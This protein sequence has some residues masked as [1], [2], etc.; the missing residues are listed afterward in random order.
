[1]A[2]KFNHS[3]AM[4]FIL[5]KQSYLSCAERLYDIYNR[6]IT[7]YLCERITEDFESENSRKEV[8]S[9]ISTINILPKIVNKLSSAYKV[10]YE[11]ECQDKKLLE[12]TVTSLNLNRKMQLCNTFLNLFRI[13]AIEPVAGMKDGQL[14]PNSVSMLRVYPAHK[15]LLMDDNTIDNNV[16]CFIKIIGQAIKTTFDVS[17][18]KDYTREVMVYEAYT[19]TEYIQFDSEGIIE[20]EDKS[21]LNEGDDENLM[22]TKHNFGRI[23]VIWMTRDIVTT[24]PPVDDDTYRM[25]TLLPL[26]FSDLN[27]ALKYKCFSIL[28]TIG[29]TLSKGAFQPNSIL[30][31]DNDSNIP[32]EKGMLG[33]IEPKVAVSEMLEAIQAQYSMWLESRGIK[34]NSLSNGASGNDMS[35]IAKAIDQGEVTEDVVE[36]RVILRDAERELFSLVG[37]FLGRNLE[38]TTTFSEVSL[39]PETNSEKNDRVI[40]KYEAGLTSWDDAVEQLNPEKNQAQMA[41]LKAAIKSEKAE[42]EA[43]EREMKEESKKPEEKSDGMGIS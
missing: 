4:C 34:I 39:L 31:L 3:E 38:V 14:L 41:A 37:L 18:R 29:L 19:E 9:R 25:V 16:V 17:S 12:D 27:Y 10:S 36:Q 13:V 2:W 1:M 20:R 30:K 23:P 42:K 6:N 28:Y 21:N 32:D 24:M 8:I 35:G 7:P 15:F 33:Q 5:S 26:L 43:K 40:K 11:R 22:I